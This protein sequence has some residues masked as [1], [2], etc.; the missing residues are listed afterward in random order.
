MTCQGHHLYAK[1]YGKLDRDELTSF[2][3]SILS[4]NEILKEPFTVF[5]LNMHLNSRPKN[6]YT[7]SKQC[8]CKIG[9]R[10]L[11]SL[12]DSILL[13][14]VCV[15]VIQSCL[16]PCDP[17]DCSPPG[18]S[19]H[20]ILQARILEWVIIAFSRGSSWSQGSNPGLLH[21]RQ[22]LYHLS[23]QGSS[24][25]IYNIMNNAVQ[26]VDIIIG[27]YRYYLIYTG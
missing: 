3:L 11:T 26:T 18:Y 19:V 7:Y 20:G 8:N 23:H 14:Y 17:K 9:G 6:K 21:F 16:T 12:T 25:N 10:W 5:K 24:I 15:L 2:T 4:A 27:Y 13:I 22:I 1:N